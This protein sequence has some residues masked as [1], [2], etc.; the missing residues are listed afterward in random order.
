MA[1]N[2][3]AA[4][5]ASFRQVLPACLLE[6]IDGNSPCRSAAICPTCDSASANAMLVTHTQNQADD[7]SFVLP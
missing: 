5:W 1:T 3:V 4:M 2:S 6:I 7:C